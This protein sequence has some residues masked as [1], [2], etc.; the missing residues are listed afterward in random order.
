MA[1]PQTVQRFIDTVKA[2]FIEGAIGVE[3]EETRGKHWW[4][5]LRAERHLLVEWRPGRGF[6]F[7]HGKEPAFGEGPTEVFVSAERAARRVVQVL[8]RKVGRLSSDLA[9]VRELY[10]LTQSQLAARLRKGQPAI[11]RLED[12]RDSKI[13]TLQEYVRGLGGRVELIAVFPDGFLPIP[14]PRYR[15]RKRAPTGLNPVARTK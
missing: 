10:G 5:N 12:G 7:S 4:I 14:V 8:T 2:A 3:A 15:G 1:Y 13:E 6:G 11:S 9:S